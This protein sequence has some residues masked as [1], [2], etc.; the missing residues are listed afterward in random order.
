M[1]DL[2]TLIV[3]TLSSLM[4]YLSPIYGVLFAVTLAF[5]LNFLFGY[6]SGIRVDGE[7]FQFRKAFSCIQEVCVFF[8]VVASVYTIGEHLDNSPETLQSIS[9][10]T[11]VALY[12]YAVNIFKNLGKLFPG[13]RWISFCYWLIAF[14][15]ARKIPYLERF[16]D[17]QGKEGIDG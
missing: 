6:L 8:L 12:F 13:S 16:I 7:T 17:K 15:F 1:E 11:Y 10:I 2:R 5:A 14:E 3:V 9:V 4:A